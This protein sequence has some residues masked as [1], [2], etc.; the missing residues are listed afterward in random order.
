[1]FAKE[2][3]MAKPDPA[4]ALLLATCRAQPNARDPHNHLPLPAG[5]Y[6]LYSVARSADSSAPKPACGCH[7]CAATE[8]FVAHPLPHVLPAGDTVIVIHGFNCTEHDGLGTIFNVRAA[9]TAWG[10]ALTPPL[11]PPH[12]ADGEGNPTLLGF[13]WPCEHTL[14]PGYMADKEAVAR[15]AAFSLAN[16]ILDLRRAEPERIIQ[17]VAHSM[18]CFLTLKALNMLA[19]LH[20]AADVAQPSVD[21]VIWLAPDINAD[22][23]ERST[24]AS[25]RLKAWRRPGQRLPFAKALLA[26]RRPT[27]EPAQPAHAAPEHPLDGY[28]YAA[29]DVVG[30]LCVYSSLNDEALWASPLANHATEE[31]G[32]AAGSIRLGWCGPLHPG[33][34]MM[35]D[36]THHH[37]RVTLVECSAVVF[38]HGAYFFV[39]ITQQ[40][41]AAQVSAAFAMRRHAP[42]LATAHPATD[43]NAPEPPPAH[44]HGVSPTVTPPARVELATWHTGRPLQYPGATETLAPGLALYALHPT[45]TTTGAMQSAPAWPT[46]GITALMPRLWRAP[47][48]GGALALLVRGWRWYY[49]V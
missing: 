11:P 9:L 22:A 2:G 33:L 28:G 26:F 49:R 12:P 8:R 16:L 37:R 29:L 7:T 4:P 30:R 41:I 31:S 36:G 19:V 45:A 20:A 44:P 35:T 13:T 38:E 24:G 10:V 27:P 17:I 15:F 21:Q 1:M 6:R 32:S 39:P 3:H 34:V 5:E 23:L 25:P 40:D 48:L 14:F 47:L 42:A 43:A 46:Q 18:G